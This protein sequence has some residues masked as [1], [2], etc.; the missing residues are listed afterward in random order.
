M[1]PWL[2]YKPTAEAINEVK[3][4]FKD[5]YNPQV[6]PGKV[7]DDLEAEQAVQR[8]LETADLPKGMRMDKPSD[9]YFAIPEFF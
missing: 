8:V 7:L 4:I 1:I 6:N 2:R 5:T 3:K 9:P